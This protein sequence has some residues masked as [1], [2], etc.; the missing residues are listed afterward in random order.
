MIVFVE[1]N[2]V[3]ELALLQHEHEECE[4]LL[5]LQ[6]E[7]PRMELALPAFSIGEAYEAWGRKFRQRSRLQEDLKREIDQLSRSRPY[8]EQSK[9]FREMTNRLLFESGEE[10]KRRLDRTLNLI[11]RSA[12][13]IPM[14]ITTVSKS[15]ELQKTRSLEPQDAIVYA[16]VLDHLTRRPRGPGCFITKNSKDFLNPDIEEDLAGYDCK[17]LTNFKD[18]L[19]YVR[20]RL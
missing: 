11:L 7:H 4:A 9:S 13:L 15:L 5:A 17:L 1:T 14:D 16:S 6:G 19:G 20:S 8:R 18:G 2:F 3:L 12:R 10:E